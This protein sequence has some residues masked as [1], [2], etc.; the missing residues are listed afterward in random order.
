MIK[1]HGI[2]F[3]NKEKKWSQSDE[4]NLVMAQKQARR[5]KE[6]RDPETNSQL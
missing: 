5:P 1:I 6:L 4:N 3:S 2:E